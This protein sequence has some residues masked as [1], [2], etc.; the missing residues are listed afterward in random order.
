MVSDGD[1]LAG[2][3]MAPSIPRFADAFIDIT[4]DHQ[5]EAKACHHCENPFD[6]G[7]NSARII[8][9]RIKYNREF[10]RSEDA[11]KRTGQRRSSFR[12]Q[13]QRTRA[14]LIEAAAEVIGEKG[15]DRASLEEI[16]AR[17]GMTRVQFTATSKVRKNSS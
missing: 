7:H 10:Y 14:K 6:V 17:A 12:R 16:A 13:A 4:G 8:Q 3:G 5:D 15:Y 9:V 1:H 11:Q 2:R